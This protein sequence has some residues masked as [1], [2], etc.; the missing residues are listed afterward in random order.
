MQKSK[1]FFFRGFR[2]IDA[3]KIKLLLVIC[4]LSINM[5]S[6]LQVLK[7]SGEP[8]GEVSLPPQH[9]EGMELPSPVSRWGSRRG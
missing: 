5:I 3:S 7:D 2:A 8:A 6:S 4:A 9:R 1:M